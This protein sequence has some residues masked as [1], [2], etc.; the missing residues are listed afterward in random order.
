[1]ARRKSLLDIKAFAGIQG[2]IDALNKIES[3]I[4]NTAVFLF[5]DNETPA[6]TMNGTNRVFTLANN[7]DP[8]DSLEL[9]LNGVYQTP[10]GED[11]DLSG[12]TITFV[13][14]HYAPESGD[15]LKAYYRHK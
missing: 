14:A 7:P 2:I 11:Y 10:G 9:Y 15:I 12:I 6:G 4:N 8:N 5:T 13:S 3:A 1:M